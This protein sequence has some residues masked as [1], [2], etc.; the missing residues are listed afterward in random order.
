[1]ST[2]VV[3]SLL[4]HT[5]EVNEQYYTYDITEMKEKQVIVGMVTKEIRN[6]QM[7][8][9]EMDLG[10]KVIKGNQNMCLAQTP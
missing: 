8:K 10:K 7:Q 1:M 4:G 9:N 2:T 5:E 3:A 6:T